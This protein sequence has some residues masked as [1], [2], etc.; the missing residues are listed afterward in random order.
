MGQIT[1]EINGKSYRMACDNGQE[2]HL[3]MLAKQFDES[4]NRLRG[5]FG[6]I[7]DNRLTVMAG[8]MVMDELVEMRRRL[9]K[10]EKQMQDVHN[11]HDIVVQQFEAAEAGLAHA[12]VICAEKVETVAREM[13][14]PITS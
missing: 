12:L 10:L 13:T 8:V 14:K 9:E 1:V 4:I 2:E 11:D 5:A 3:Y 6:E 7:G